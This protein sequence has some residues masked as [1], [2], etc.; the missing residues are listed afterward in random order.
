MAAATKL[1]VTSLVPCTI[2]LLGVDEGQR[3]EFNVKF[4]IDRSSELKKLKNDEDRQASLDAVLKRAFVWA[5]PIEVLKLDDQQLPILDEHGE[6]E[7]VTLAGKEAI[8]YCWDD[9]SIRGALFRA[10][11]EVKRVQMEKNCFG[12]PDSTLAT[13]PALSVPTVGSSE[14][15]IELIQAV[16][17]ANSLTPSPGPSASASPSEEPSASQNEE[18]SPPLN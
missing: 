17:Q 7:F 18:P 8:A 5:A 1:T 6:P 12:L 10:L 4:Y 11:M 14:Q 16:Q 15:V 3:Q 9:Q 13:V 2:V